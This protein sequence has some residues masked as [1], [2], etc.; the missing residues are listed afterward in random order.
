M[1]IQPPPAG[2]TRVRGSVLTPTATG[3]VT[4][5]DDAVVV[6]RNGRVDAVRAPIA[7]D[8]PATDLLLLPGFVDLHC[9]WP[10]SHVRGQFAGALLP[11]LRE[12]IWPAE[13]AFSQDDEAR[14]RAA[15]FV[16][17][18]LRAGTTA[19]MFFGPPFL[20]ASLRFLDVAPHGMI[21]GPAMMEVNCPS[22][23]QT[24]AG[25]MIAAIARLPDATRRRLTIAP[26]FAPNLTPAG[27]SA[28]GL[29][30]TSL[31]LRAQSHLS[32]NLDEVAWVGQLFPEANSYT[33]V[34]DRAGLLGP[35]VVMAHGVHLSDGE[36]ARLAETGT[37]IA[38]CPTSNEALGSGRMPVERLRAAGVPWVLATDVGAGPQLSQLHVMATFLAQ[39]AAAG[40]TVTAVEALER[41]T[42]IPGAWLAKGDPALAGLGTLGQNA[43]AHMT[44]FARPQGDDPEAV[45]RGLLA[46]GGPSY[47][48]AARA[49]WSW[50]AQVVGA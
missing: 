6:L 2:P 41:A 42:S 9:H 14:R 35:H 36:L 20:A 8:P 29:A 1:T 4:L 5:R 12:S 28:C 7:G 44:A 22:A 43:P 13:A 15:T 30:A 27:L 40:V 49:V 25:E 10:Q 23:L 19:G 18:L 47:E 26:R 45:L 34:Y 37:T 48:S 39:H 46:Q 11:W 16:S 33:D 31:R 50:G 38:H 3:R 32:E 17:A 21:D 24:P